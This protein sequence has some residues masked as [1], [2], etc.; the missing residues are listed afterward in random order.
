[1][2]DEHGSRSNVSD[3]S[4][5]NPVTRVIKV[6]L[7][8][9][10][11]SLFKSFH[12]SI[13][14]FIP[15][16]H[17]P[18]TIWA[19]NRPGAWELSIARA[20]KCITTLRVASQSGG[21]LI[22]PEQTTEPWEKNADE[23]HV[24]LSQSGKTRSSQPSRSILNVSLSPQNLHRGETIRPPGSVFEMTQASA[25]LPVKEQWNVTRG[26]CRPHHER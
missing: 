17:T 22:Q 14:A 18:R 6:T 10:A 2:N 21:C 20:A 8:T 19:L 26:L 15:Y 24:A 9:P 7:P 1:M 3:W 12:T 4:S 16:A 13:R 23:P 11:I 5:S 25:G